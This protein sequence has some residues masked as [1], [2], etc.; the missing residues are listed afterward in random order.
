M[1]NEFRK[2]KFLLIIIQVEIIN[3]RKMQRNNKNN[4]KLREKILVKT[5]KNKE[6][7][8]GIRNKPKSR[9][10]AETRKQMKMAKKE[11]RK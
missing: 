4:E 9:K 5:D 10:E 6:V 3:V 7:R 2:Q 11:N 8:Y 1:K